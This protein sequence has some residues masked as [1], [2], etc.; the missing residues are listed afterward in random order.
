MKGR[1]DKGDQG[2]D[3][4]SWWWDHL[5]SLTASALWARII[6]VCR[7]MNISAPIVMPSSSCGA[8]SASPVRLSR[9]PG[10]RHQLKS[11]SHLLPLSPRVKVASPAR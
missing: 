11:C 1:G 9:A 10:V 3:D 6:V 7:Y 5:A 4:H 8:P 2:G